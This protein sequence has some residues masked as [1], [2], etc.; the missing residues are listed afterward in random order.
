MKLSSLR[1]RILL[2]GVATAV[3]TVLLVW[4]AGSLAFH[5]MTSEMDLENVTAGD[6]ALC[7]RAPEAWSKELGGFVSVFAY[8]LATGISA[9]PEAP[10]LD[11]ALAAQSLEPAVPVAR[12][13]HHARVSLVRMADAGPCSLFQVRIRPPPERSIHAHVVYLAVGGVAAMFAVAALSWLLAVRPIVR[14][15]HRLRDAAGGV[16]REGYAAAAD[17]TGD[18]LSHISDV[19]DASHARIRADREELVARHE[20]LE[21]HLA[22]IA[23]DLRT[24]LASLLLATEEL[25]EAAGQGDG[26]G[27]GTPDVAARALEDT[28]YLDALVDNLRQATLLRH[29][30]DP[31]A[32]DVRADLG[33]VAR[34]VGQRFAALGRRRQVE[35]G[36]AVPDEPVWAR[37]PPALAE[38][39]LANLVHNAVVHGKSGGHVAV[40]LEAKGGRFRLTVLDDGPGVPPERLADLALRTFRDDEARPRDQGLGLAI[41]NEVCRRAGWA[42]RYSTVEDGGLLVEVSGPML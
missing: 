37:C 10:P 2:S 27:S 33:E 35:V 28:V 12:R 39:A 14:R 5:R 16:G 9:N 31:L 15:I 30:L 20:A 29:G 17:R 3:V 24:P 13:D 18:E 19:L 36:W 11:T 32:G 25:S 42:I 1:T 41:T 34:R 40:V 7:G 26:G 8:D 38:R 21:R 23:H 22:E 4:L 6:V